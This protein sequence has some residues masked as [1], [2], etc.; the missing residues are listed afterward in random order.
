MVNSNCESMWANKSGA[1]LGRYP[2][3]DYGSAADVPEKQAIIA[4]KRCRSNMLILCIN[5]FMTND[6]KRK[7]RAFRTAYIFDNQDDGATM[8][9]S[10]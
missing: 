8:F 2:T 9:L 3:A 7:L 6:S 5:N 1:N 10:L 4:Q